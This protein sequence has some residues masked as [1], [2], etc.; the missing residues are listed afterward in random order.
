MFL[1][2]CI[3]GL[4]LLLPCACSTS[5]QELKVDSLS[6][7]DLFNLTVHVIDTSGFVVDDPNPH[8]GT[9]RTKWDHNKLLDV[10]RFP[11]RRRAEAH[12]DPLDDGAYLV[13]LRI[14]EEANNYGKMEVERSDKGW[15]FYGY[16]KVKTQD[17]LTRIKLLVMEWKPSDKFYERYK[18]LDDLREAIPEVLGKPDSEEDG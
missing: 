5:W 12:I 9:I 14:E 7:S 4:L 1:K 11:I 13:R 17:I 2:S 8:T 16:D 6:F 15:Q 3:A 18:R 10:G